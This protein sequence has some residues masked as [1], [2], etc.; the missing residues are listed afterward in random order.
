M[1][2]PIIFLS[3]LGADERVFARQ[4]AA[5]DGLLVGKW[6]APEAG[7]SLPEY[8]K[9]LAR[10]I[11]PGGPCYVG[12][13]SFGGMVAIEMSAPLQARA[14]FL[15]SSVRSPDELPR[16]IRMLRGLVRNLPVSAVRAAQLA[17]RLMRPAARPLSG[18]VTRAAIDQFVDA[19]PELIRWGAGAILS[20]VRS[21]EGCDVPVFQIH[22]RSDWVLPHGNTR[23]DHIVNGGGHL[24]TIS[25]AEQVNRFIR[26]RIATT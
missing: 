20:W 13:I 26:E 12:G 18:P 16:R 19:D 25:H 9:R 4:S 5:L 2:R 3:G 17:T 11:D 14:C 8:A 15:I 24:L 21:G 7:E 10:Q 6:I 23:P 1:T 22:G